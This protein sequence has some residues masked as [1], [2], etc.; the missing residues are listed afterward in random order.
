MKLIKVIGQYSY[1]LSTIG[2]LNVE[3]QE[4]DVESPETDKPVYDETFYNVEY[5]H[6]FSVSGNV[7]NYQLTN[8]TKNKLLLNLN[9]DVEVMKTHLG[10]AVS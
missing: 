10:W 6:A 9:I 5:N 3:K 2:W 7:L 8:V 4:A 1:S